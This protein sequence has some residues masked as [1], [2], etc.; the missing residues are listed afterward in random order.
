MSIPTRIS[1][2][3][4]VAKTLKLFATAKHGPTAVAVERGYCRS[5]YF[6]KAASTKEYDVMRRS[7]GCPPATQQVFQSFNFYGA[8]LPELS[9]LGCD[10]GV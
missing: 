3:V 5:H 10:I 4:N 6:A 8:R 1:S 9:L 2:T 7:T